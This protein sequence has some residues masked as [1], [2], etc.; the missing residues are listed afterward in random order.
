MKRCRN[1]ASLGTSAAFKSAAQAVKGAGGVGPINAASCIRNE[2]GSASTAT[3]G[4]QNKS[5]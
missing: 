1:A 4:F 5:S 3:D 2:A